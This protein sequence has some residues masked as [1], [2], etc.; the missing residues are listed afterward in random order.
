VTC[1]VT[2]GYHSTVLLRHGPNVGLNTPCEFEICVRTEVAPEV[3]E[4]L[5]PLTLRSTYTLYSFLT[6]K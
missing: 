3:C 1:S 6:P 4:T 2:M 5:A